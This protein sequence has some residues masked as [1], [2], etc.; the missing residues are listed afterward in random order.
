MVC[1]KLIGCEKGQS[2]VT[3]GLSPK[4]QAQTNT[5]EQSKGPV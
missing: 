4:L 2:S 5:R 3:D 1:E